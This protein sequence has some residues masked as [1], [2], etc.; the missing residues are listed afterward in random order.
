M[1]LV[2]NPRHR[3][4]LHRRE[5]LKV[6]EKEKEEATGEFPNEK[7]RDSFSLLSTNYP[8]G[9]GNRCYKIGKL[10]NKSSALIPLIT[11]TLI[12]QIT[13][14]GFSEPAGL[15]MLVCVRWGIDGE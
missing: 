12:S 5:K 11:K 6:G 13:W 8:N 15:C 4:F 3:H 1:C 7:E 9:N 2:R 14:V 10:M